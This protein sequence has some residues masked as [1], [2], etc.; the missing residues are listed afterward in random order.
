[1]EDEYIEAKNLQLIADRAGY[2][3]TGIARS[4]PEA[5]DLI[6]NQRPDLV[7]LDI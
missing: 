2:E 5:L 4:V 3:V 1:M 7:L 6:E